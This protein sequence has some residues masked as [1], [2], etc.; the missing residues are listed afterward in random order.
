M[1]APFGGTCVLELIGESDVAGAV[2]GEAMTTG[3]CDWMVICGGCEYMGASAVRACA[4][5][6]RTVSVPRSTSGGTSDCLP[7]AR[8]D[9]ITFSGYPILPEM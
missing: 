7:D 2:A 5:I 8:R 6:S 4:A 1:A 3:V 9:V